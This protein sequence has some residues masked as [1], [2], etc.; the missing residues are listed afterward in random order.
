M[1]ENACVETD[2]SNKLRSLAGY[3]LSDYR[4]CN[5]FV[6]SPIAQTILVVLSLHTAELTKQLRQASPNHT[7]NT[8][9]GH[10]KTTE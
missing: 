8:H 5:S 10:A 7:I 9:F 1:K 3:L 4:D 2:Q 6:P